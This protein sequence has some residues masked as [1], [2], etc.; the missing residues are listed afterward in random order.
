MAVMSVLAVQQADARLI[1]EKTELRMGRDAAKQIESQYKVSNDKAAN[2][3]VAQ[4]GRRMAAVSS[5]PNL[6]WQFK[7]LETKE[8]NAFSVPGYVYINRGLLDFVGEDRDA[9]AGVIGHEIGHTTAH[10]AVRSAEKQIKYSIA[11]KLLLKGDNAQQLGSIAA[12]LALL[13]Y[14]R[15][16]EYH[17]DKL[18]VEYMAASGCDPNGMLR[19]FNKLQAKEGKEPGGLAVYFRTHPP[20]ADRITRVQQEITTLSHKGLPPTGSQKRK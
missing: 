3:L 18:G 5:R 4:M 16:E 10:H 17:A 6:P 11:L 7:V 2:D 14:G 13:G 19:F 9:L 12:N 15:K 8:I 1:G 20:T